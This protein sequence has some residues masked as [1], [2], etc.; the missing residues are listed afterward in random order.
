M[1][2]SVGI[3]GLPNVGKSTV[4]NALTAGKAE[5]A[6]YPF[7]TIDPNVG[8]VPVPDARL[9]RIVKHIPTQKVIPAVVEI[10]DIAGLVKGASQGEGLGNKFLANIRETNAVLMMVRCFDD[11]NVIHVAGSVDPMRDIDIIDL[12]LCLADLDT[13]EKRLKKAQSAAKSG[14]KE[15][16]TE[17]ALAEK[18]FAHLEA[19]KP[20]RSLDLPV[21]DKKQVA[22]WG[23]LTTKPVLYCCNVGE[24]DLPAGNAW[25]DQVRARAKTEDAGVV[26]LC[27]KIEAELAEVTDPAEQAELLAAYGLVEP[28][29]ASLARECYRLLGLQSYFT[30]GEKEVRAWTVRKGALA[31]E[32]A[33][34]IHTD[35][36]KGFIRA[37]VYSIPDLEQLGSEAAIKGAGKMRMEGKEY[38]VQDGDVMHFLF[39]V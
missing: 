24:G 4:F 17:L 18:V 36:E 3:V 37:Q 33:G 13:A 29:L 9:A 21:E 12:E 26:I 10:V 7:C 35:F 20:G 14:G 25:S 27:G 23:L 1:A 28:A 8:I 39:N 15:A 16:K 11:G 2:L 31:P 6:N 5:A 30:A 38:V 34:V 32:A 22:T 19:G